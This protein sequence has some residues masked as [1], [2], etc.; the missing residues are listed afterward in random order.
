MEE[1][2][3]GYLKLLKDICDDEEEEHVGEENLMSM[4]EGMEKDPSSWGVTKE[5]AQMWTEDV[6]QVTAAWFATIFLVLLFM[7]LSYSEGAS[8]CEKSS[9]FA[10][11]MG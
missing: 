2:R 3:K 1:W 6:K 8:G 5:E 10:F 4:L 11:K 7:D 9:S